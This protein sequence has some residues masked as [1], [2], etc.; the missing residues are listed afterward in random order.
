MIEEYWP[1]LQM[2]IHE[3][4]FLKTSGI[5]SRACTVLK[6]G[7]YWTC[8]FNYTQ[9]WPTHNYLLLRVTST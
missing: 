6:I 7:R 5:K 4:C 1:F 9:D 2:K 8:R 3:K